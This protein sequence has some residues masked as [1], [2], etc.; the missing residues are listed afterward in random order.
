MVRMRN[1]TPAGRQPRLLEQVRD[2]VRLKRY[3]MRTEEAYVG[4]I[5]RFILFHGK[6]HPRDMGAEEVQQFLTDLA[7]MRRVAATS[8]RRQPSSP[9]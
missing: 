9:A 6:R 1:A 3:S 8:R 4:W 2:I 7:V 5:K